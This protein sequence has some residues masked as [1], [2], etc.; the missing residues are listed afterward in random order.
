MVAGSDTF[1]DEMLKSYS[2]ANAF[3]NLNRYSKVSL[4]DLKLMDIDVIFLSL[5]PYLFKRKYIQEFQKAC[6]K[7]N[8][9]VTD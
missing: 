3:E 4:K 7:A 2:A 6:L 9:V 1:I 5:E 8:I